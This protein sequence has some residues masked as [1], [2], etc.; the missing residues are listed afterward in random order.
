MTHSFLKVILD[1]IL[2]LQKNCVLY[3][4]NSLPRKLK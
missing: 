1:V 3:R 2:I 4:E